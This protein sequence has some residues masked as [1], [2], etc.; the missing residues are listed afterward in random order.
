MLGGLSVVN[1]LPRSATL[2]R[3]LSRDSE[4]KLRSLVA[5]LDVRNPRGKT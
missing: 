1:D 2:H 3:V 5:P 4:I